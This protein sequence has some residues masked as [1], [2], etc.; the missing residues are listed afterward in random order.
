MLVLF[1]INLIFINKIFGKY[2]KPL[3]KQKYSL[4]EMLDFYCFCIFLIRAF[5]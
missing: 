1:S 4:W 3:S 2:L 5:D